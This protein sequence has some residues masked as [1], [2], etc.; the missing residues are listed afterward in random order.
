MRSLQ[1]LSS[2]ASRLGSS[3]GHTWPWQHTAAAAQYSAAAAGAAASEAVIEV[4]QQGS[5]AVVELKR[6]KA[7]NA[8]STQVMHELVDA[9]MQL[10]ADSSVRAIIITGRGKAFAAG[11]DIREMVGLDHAQAEQQQLFARW[12]ELATGRKC[13]TPLIAAVN[14]IALGGGAELAMLC[15]IIIAST[16]AS[17]GL[18][19]VTLGVIPGIGGTQRL[20]R[21]VGRARAMDAML[22]ARR[23]SA[24]EAL[25]WGL[26]SRL[27]PPEQL[28]P[29]AHAIAD[30][31][32]SLSPGA[33]AR[34]LQAS[35]AAENMPLDAALLEER[36]LFYGC[37]GTADQREGMGA[38]LEKR[39]PVFSR[40]KQLM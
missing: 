23:V 1:L 18:P 2:S 19:E 37:F 29:E 3:L 14:G 26:V 33:V 6:P 8:L 36:R 20:P 4:T 39:Q 31:L 9:V 24:E 5:S 15:D 38:F 10:D 32:A 17:F 35:H 30:K 11:A 34:M 12:Q 28:L 25:S 7:L 40:D 21:L 13:W 27:V 22:T 16:A